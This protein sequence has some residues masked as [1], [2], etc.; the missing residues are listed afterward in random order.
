M[1][2]PFSTAQQL[3]EDLATIAALGGQVR[4]PRDC[5][6]GALIHLAPEG[7]NSE[8]AKAEQRKAF[9]THFL[10]G[11]QDSDQ[12]VEMYTLTGTAQEVLEQLQAKADWGSEEIICVNVPRNDRDQFRA[13]RPDVLP[14]R[15]V[16]LV[17]PRERPTCSNPV[18]CASVLPSVQG[19]VINYL[20]GL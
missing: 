17:P 12:T 14:A 18:T 2:N 9:R 5:I 20:R 1:I 8:D 4:G 19:R 3:E 13:I 16:A 7:M 10:G 15:F 6:N 11:R